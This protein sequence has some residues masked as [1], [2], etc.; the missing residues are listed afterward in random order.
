ME[1]SKT[2]HCA[3]PNFPCARGRISSKFMNGSDTHPQMVP[4]ALVRTFFACCAGYVYRLFMKL[5]VAS[6]AVDFLSALL[7]LRS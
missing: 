5:A 4:P 7:Q 6:L 2:P 3:F 1:D